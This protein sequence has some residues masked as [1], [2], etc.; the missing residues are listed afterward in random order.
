MALEELK[1]ALGVAAA[2]VANAAKEAVVDLTPYAQ[3]GLQDA[4][5]IVTRMTLDQQPQASVLGMAGVPTPGEVD[6][7]LNGMGEQQAAQ[8]VEAPAKSEEQVLSEIDQKW[9]AMVQKAQ[10]APEQ[11]QGMSLG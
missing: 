7:N 4:Q 5:N 2:G 8:A 11:G 10:E 6:R 3:G 9:N 1:K